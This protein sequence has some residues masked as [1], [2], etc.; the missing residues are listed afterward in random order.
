MLDPD[1]SE[2]WLNWVVHPPG[3]PAVGYVQA[4]VML[5]HTAWVGCVF[6]ARHRG[7]GYATQA[8][9]AMLEH[10]ACAC[11]VSRFL[12]SVEAKNQSSIRLLGR[13]CFREASGQELTAHGLAPTERLFVKMMAA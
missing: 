8:V 10:V 11:G 5:N 4:T 2:V 3:L 13:L 12:A 9:Q 7:R 1:G 6:S